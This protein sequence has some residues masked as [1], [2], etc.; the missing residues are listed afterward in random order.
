[1]LHTSWTRFRLFCAAYLPPNNANWPLANKKS[2]RWQLCVNSDVK[3]CMYEMDKKHHDMHTLH[4]YIRRTY[5][6]IAPE[7]ECPYICTYA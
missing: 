1:M 5:Y 4:M 6:K 3:E 7:G 2:F